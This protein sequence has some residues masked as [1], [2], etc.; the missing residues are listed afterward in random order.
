MAGSTDA[1]RAPGEG[2]V[3]EHAAGTPL[4]AYL[5]A[6]SP[7]HDALAVFRVAF[8]DGSSLAF[9]AG[10]FVRLG[11]RAPPRVA[12]GA[13]RLLQRAYSI[14][15]AVGEPEVELFLRRVSAGRLSPG[16]FALSPGDEL[17]MDS[18][19]YGS[20]TLAGIPAD[21]DLV[22][23][24][25]GTGV[26]P[27]LSMLRTHAR[28]A[29]RP[30]RRVALVLGA[31]I[32]LDLG[33]ADELARLVIAMPEL[34]YHPLLSRE[35]VTSGWSGL[36]GRVQDLLDAARWSRYVPFELDPATAHVLLCGNPEMIE[37]VI[38]LLEARGF[39]RSRRDAPGTLRTERY[40]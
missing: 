20:F 1:D 29:Q 33:Y 39:Q 34:T 27:Y 5:V 6:K 9:E 24:A 25:T 21:R 23:V 36:R 28:V 30:W 3:P 11:L 40:W 22:L 7:L 4:N 15:S 2:P 26:A 14:A 17:H 8:R 35:P 31:R 12:G 38:A 13:P 32:A 37:E 18:R 19:A 10:Q 16:L